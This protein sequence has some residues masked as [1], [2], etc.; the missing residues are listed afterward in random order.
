MEDI[1]W[2]REYHL[3]RRAGW[4]PRALLG[5]VEEEQVVLGGK[6][7]RLWHCIRRGRALRVVNWISFLE[8]LGRQRLKNA[9]S[10][11]AWPSA[12]AGSLNGRRSPALS[13]LKSKGGC[14]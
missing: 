4:T 7:R 9:R 6:A 13:E 1:A 10:K 14:W 8:E 2:W 12:R 5:E 3:G 11:Q